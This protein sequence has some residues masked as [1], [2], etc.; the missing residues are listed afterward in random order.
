MD[1][2]VLVY[3][4]ER[5]GGYWARVAELPGCLTQGK[6]IDEVRTNVI[7]AIECYLEGTVPEKH[8]PLAATL[9]VHI[10]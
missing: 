3:Q 4:E 1:Y 10:A 2:T 7:D 8:D 6:T 5:D 9:A